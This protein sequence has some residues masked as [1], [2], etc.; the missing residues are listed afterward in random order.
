MQT[1]RVLACRQPLL[2]ISAQLK[3]AYRLLEFPGTGRIIPPEHPVGRNKTRSYNER[4]LCS[5]SSFN[6][7]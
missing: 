5:L 6:R 3:P 2:R 1:G 4:A 7:W